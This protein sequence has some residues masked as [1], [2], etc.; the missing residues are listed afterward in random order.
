[1]PAHRLNDI[2]VAMFLATH[3]YFTTYHVCVSNGI[4][5]YV[6][7]S[8]A[9]GLRKRILFWFTVLFLSY[10]TAF[11]ET[12]TISS[13]PYYSF[14]DRTVAYVWGSA[15]YGI[16]FIVSFPGFYHFDTH[17]D[18]GI[19]LSSSEEKIRVCGR[20]V[21]LMGTFTTACGHGMMILTLLDFVR[22]HLGIPLVIG[23]VA[24]AST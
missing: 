1:M 11:M 3:F 24:F 14:E 9:G 4:F 12:L 5:R 2:P 21:T 6:D 13:F 18:E 19:S 8:Y 23:G 16:Y 17:V 7:R 10:F 15:F 20:P 22:L